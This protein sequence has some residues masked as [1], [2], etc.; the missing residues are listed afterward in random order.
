MPFAAYVMGDAIQ[1]EQVMLNIVRNAIEAIDAS[2]VTTK[3]VTITTSAALPRA[4]QIRISDNGSLA[5]ELDPE[6]IF[7][8]FF[9]TKSM[10]M[11]MGLPISR[12]IVEAH[13]GQLNVVSNMP[14]RG[15]TFVV[16]LPL[17]QQDYAYAR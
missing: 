9:T 5:T 2:D 12:S 8:P 7:E 4:V 16:T 17:T 13:R 1:L 10:G 3:I 14:E 11:G 15:L 6:K